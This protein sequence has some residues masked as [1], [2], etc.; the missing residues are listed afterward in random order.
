MKKQLMIVGIIVLLVCVG[1]SGCEQKSTDTEDIVEKTHFTIAGTITNNYAEDIDIDYSIVENFNEWA[2]WAPTI[3]VTS[4]EVKN[5]SCEVKLGYELYLLIAQWFYPNTDT[6]GCLM[7]TESIENTT[8]E[9][10]IFYIEVKNNG[11]IQI[12]QTEPKLTTNKAP[13]VTIDAS[14]T[15]GNAPLTVSFTSEAV[16]SDGSI[17]NYSWNFDDGNT[18]NEHNPTH[19]FQDS[20]TYKVK[21]TIIDETG[22]I[23][24][25]TINIIAEFPE[26][27]II[28]HNSV[29]FGGRIE[30][31][32][33]IKNV[34]PSSI[35][36]DLPSVTLYDAS[37]NYIDRN[38]GS[39][40]ADALAPAIIG[41]QETA[42]FCT[43]II[44]SWF[45]HYKIDI[46]FQI[47]KTN[48]KPYAETKGLVITNHYLEPSNLINGCGG[49]IK[50]T[51]SGIVSD[52][53]IV[54]AFY[55]SSGNL[56]YVDVV[57]SH[58]KLYS[59]QEYN[60]YFGLSG[61]P[62]PVYK[63]SS[64]DIEIGEEV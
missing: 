29:E 60:F 25:D 12:S 6:E 18:T 52:F 1:L 63:I 2:Y 62:I 39:S 34:G 49:T 37:N 42:I 4:Y 23:G 7:V 27:V 21:L 17:V 14:I 16:D 55:D 46:S 24:T 36:L 54:G 3:R 30:V 43:Q 57:F 13:T 26:P 19:I 59:G 56:V 10:L 48:A 35:K 64:Y 44:A 5:F 45:D 15:S 11:E 51:G 58:P 47:Q 22:N 31:F 40:W 50:N 32:G 9:D 53:D 41:P 38:L 33:I 28:A 61:L 8:G 20:G